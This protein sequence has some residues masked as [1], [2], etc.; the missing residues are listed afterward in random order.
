MGAGREG[1][2]RWVLRGGGATASA[3]TAVPAP[4]SGA[5]ERDATRRRNLPRG[6]RRGQLRG[7][8]GREA[9]ASPS[10]G[11]GGRGVASRRRFAPA[12]SRK[13]VASLTPTPQPPARQRR[14]P[15]GL[16]A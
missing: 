7:G 12:R 1:W 9:G 6:G 4:L 16:A 2:R 15:G 11:R 13:V 5:A 3:S 8:A 14:G 10:A